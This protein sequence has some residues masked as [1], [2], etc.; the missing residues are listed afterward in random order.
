MRKFRTTPIL[1]AGALA[2]SVAST[3]RGQTVSGTVLYALT[4]PSGGFT[5]YDPSESSEAAVG[6]QVVGDA[7]GSGV[8]GGG[9]QATLWTATGTPVDLDPANFS[10]SVA[11]GTGGGQQV[12][13]G[14]GS[15][16][17]GETNA[18]LWTAG[19]AAS[20]VDLNP[21]SFTASYARATTGSQQ[22]GY[23]TLSG[24]TVA[25]VW[26]N[27]AASGFN[28][29]PSGYSLSEAFGTD[30]AQQVG[31]GYLT[32]TFTSQAL[33][34]TDTASAINLNPTNLTGY[35][36]SIAEGISGTQEVG[37][38]YGTATSNNNHAMLWNSSSGSAVDLNPTVLSDFTVSV[39]DGT[40][41]MQQVGY[42]NVGSSDDAI[43]LLWSGTAASA[44]NLQSL[45]PASGT[46]EFS[47]AYS[48]DANGNIFGTAYGTYDS[49]TGYFAVEW[50]P[51]PDPASFSVLA[52]G[53]PTL[54]LR[55]RRNCANR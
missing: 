27:T 9:L 13:N 45:L 48:I 51:V 39:A 55:R 46:W 7:N 52:L 14:S 24:K 22:V 8:N 49:S 3:A 12:G 19:T 30:G 26:T 36:G 33:L 23:G 28:L 44:V 16:T 11:M 25:L 38:A 40:N 6:G 21:T 15:A 17:S 54:L 47:N 18:L 2:L 50:S 42:G 1:A 41:G 29:N 4:L 5:N 20:A 10:S 34:W 31:Y 32:G 53:L 35:S 43:A 37:L